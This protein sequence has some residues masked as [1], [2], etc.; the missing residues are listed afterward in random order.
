VFNLRV[1]LINPP[2]KTQMA[3]IIFTNMCEPL[4]L[5]YIAAVLEKN[6]VKVKVI[7]GIAERLSHED[8]EGKIAG[9]KPD[10]VGVASMMAETYRDAAETVKIARRA[11]PEAKIVIGG[12]NASFVA[13]KIIENLPD[14]D[15][16]VV[17]EGEYTFLELAQA[18]ENGG[19][20]S[21]VKGL[22]LRE[23]GRAVFTGP[24]EPIQNLDELPFPAKHLLSP[25]ASYGRFQ[26]AMFNVAFKNMSGVI[27]TRGCPFGCTFCSCTAFS[28]RKIRARSPEN[29]V[30]EMEYLVEKR[31]VEHIFVVDDNFT[32]FPKRVME[33]CKLMKERDI[34]VNW[35][36]EGRVDTAS[37][38][39]Y[40]AMSD[41][42]CWLIF[43]GLESGSQRVLD[44]YEKKTT[45]EKGQRAVALAQ[46]A[47]IDVVGSFIVGAP[48]ETEEEYLKTLEFIKRAD[49][50]AISISSLK[51]LPGAELWRRFEESG[52]IKPEDWNNYLEIFDVYGGHSKEKIRRWMKEIENGF[53]FRPGYLVKE[54]WRM[55]GRRRHM[56]PHVVRN[57]F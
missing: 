3:G 53:Y 11:V 14:V 56:I 39:M 46:K 35:F 34:D 32:C 44:Y 16:V 28:G 21:R 4:G 42:G 1:L 2:I 23:N 40:K 54:L 15:Y 47:G 13:G 19:D 43:L 52:A 30:A 8:L 25:N 9:F 29:V 33:I 50:D 45:V 6:G 49:M 18:L 51:V 26:V 55:F 48:N 24:R 31:G 36:C 27:T 7:D 22:M 20:V 10:V 5:L 57:L 17:G 37:W 41:A 12:H 38:E